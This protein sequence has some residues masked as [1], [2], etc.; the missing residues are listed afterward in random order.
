MKQFLR[1][2]F[3]N[4]LG[5]QRPILDIV[6]NF[7]PNPS[8]TPNPVCPQQI[9][10]SDLGLGASSFPYIAGTYTR[11][12]YNG[13][14]TFDGGYFSGGTGGSGI[15][16]FGPT[17]S[18]STFA[19]Y[20]KTS[21][22]TYQTIIGW[23]AQDK[24]L[25]VNSTSDILTGSFISSGITWA[26]GNP[27]TGITVSNGI[28][29]LRP[30]YQETLFFNFIP[31]NMVVTYPSACPTPTPSASQPGSVTPTPT[32]TP[33]TTSPV[34][35]TPTNTGTPTPTPTNTGSP[36]PTPSATSPITPTPTNTGTPTPTPTTPITFYILTENSD[37]ITTENNDNINFEN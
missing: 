30:G 16:T 1:K 33:S 26:S 15:V 28:S 23:Y 32:P 14:Q 13:T 19:I 10:I 20:Q 4:Y 17:L 24:I 12:T 8:A 11:V 37:A 36:T 25:F 3:S 31:G 6:A 18:G 29:Y 34:T 2:E 9:T 35:P 22:A 5:E 27:W 21:G 7:V